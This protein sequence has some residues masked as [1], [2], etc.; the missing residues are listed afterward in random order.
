MNIILVKIITVLKTHWQKRGERPLDFVL[1]LFIVAIL[2]IGSGVNSGSSAVAMTMANDFELSLAPNISNITNS[3]ENA[4]QPKRAISEAGIGRKNEDLISFSFHNISLTYFMNLLAK[5]SGRN[6][7]VHPSA[8]QNMTLH[9]NKMTFDEILETVLLYSDLQKI[10]RNNVIFIADEK[11]YNRINKGV[12]VT[13]V[14]PLNYAQAAELIAML[15]SH[16]FDGGVLRNYEYSIGVDERLNQLIVT[17]QASEVAKIRTI[18]QK[19][20]QPA[21]QVE[22]S[23]YIVAAFDDFAKELGVNWG[24]SYTSGSH[25]V[26]GNITST[27]TGTGGFGESLG[28]L[29]SLGV[30]NPHFSIAYMVLGNGLNLGLEISA[31]QSEGRGEMI[32]N[33]TVLTTSRQSAYIKQGTEVSYSTSSNEGTNTQFKEVVM[34]LN[35]TPQITPSNKIMID[36]FI[37]KD[38]I[39]GYSPKGEP[40]IA[41]KELK[42]QAIVSHGETIVLGGI[43]EYDNI[44]GTSEVP[45]LS[46]LPF[47]GNLFKREMKERR[48]AELLIFISPRIIDTLI[49]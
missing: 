23:A 45:F 1:K 31:M 44:E 14:I 24:L 19:L 4:L 35:V 6:I 12:L 33:P 27:Q 7:V 47:V 36:I 5:E 9:L 26:E 25:N 38:E 40:V 21:R 2:L 30:V 18:I 8:E 46:R 49:Y 43:Y 28:S 42:T 13:E 16:R 32:S 29:T 41:K 15:E 39:A 10:E 3:S 11:A 20:D 34:E 17:D 48:K 37:S 22:I